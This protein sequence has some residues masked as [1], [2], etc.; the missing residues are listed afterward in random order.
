MGKHGYID[1]LPT[2]DFRINGKPVK[3]A[4]EV[5]NAFKNADIDTR[6]DIIHAL[7]GSVDNKILDIF[8][9]KFN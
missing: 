5:R 7:Y 9:S 2:I 8:N 1:T 6:K 4:S 3:S